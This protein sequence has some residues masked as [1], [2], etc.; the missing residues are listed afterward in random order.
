MSATAGVFS[1]AAVECADLPDLLGAVARLSQRDV[2]ALSARDA[3]GY[4]LAC[5]RLRSALD[6]RRAV[7][8]DTLA[9]H[10]D[11]DLQR[12][13]HDQRRGGVPA[14]PGPELHGFVASML[15]PGLHC[16]TRTVQRRLEADRRLVCT[17]ASTHQALWD[18]DLDLPRADAVAEAARSVDPDLWARFEALVLETTVDEVTGEITL[19]SD[20]V[21]R[22]SRSAF[23][24][25]AARIART[26]DPA[27]QCRAAKQARDQRRVVI[28]PDRH[29]PGMAVW[30]AHLPTDVSQ[31][32]AAAVDALAG[33]YAKANPGTSIDSRRADALTALVL[34]NAE[35]KTVVE[36][37]IP[38]LPTPDQATRTRGALGQLNPVTATLT[39]GPVPEGTIP[40]GTTSDGAARHD[41]VAWVIP[42]QVDDPRHGA[43]APDVIAQLLAD[44]DVILRLARLDPDGSIT[45]D[46][47]AYRPSGSTRRRVRARDGSCRFP[48]CH[49]PA[50]RTDTDH[51][52]AHPHG[53]YCR[54]GP[55]PTAAPSPPTPARTTCAT[56]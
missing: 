39:D 41:T 49:T 32:M 6:A 15:A 42:G 52:T 11:E 37:L 54:S 16:S 22:M 28:R 55:P 56:T 48:G 8:M 10:L 21:R 14:H 31:Q 24:R 29:Q 51:V 13:A 40:E 23:A 12:R 30:T 17:T 5:D 2:A 46:P 7:A 1:P 34:G 43:L 47:T 36:L 26:L 35:V 44:P 45:Q 38:V 4:V 9:A 19:V 25:R 53:Y 3:E 20:E 50:A 33:S 27:S 18:G